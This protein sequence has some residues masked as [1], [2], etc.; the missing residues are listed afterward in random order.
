ML[1]FLTL[2]LVLSSLAMAAL[3]YVKHWELTT[4][5]L[6]FAPI[7]PY[8]SRIAARVLAVFEHHVP[9]ASARAVR[10]SV[11]WTRT[12]FRDALARM[13]LTVEHS[14]EVMLDNL[15]HGLTSPRGMGGQASSAFLREVAEHKRK[16]TRVTRIRRQPV[17]DRIANSEIR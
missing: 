13:L 15:K 7:R 12:R 2:I 10:Y 3:L 14:L 17:D 16:L 9:N 4:G 1:L 5:R 11:R 8:V 6:M